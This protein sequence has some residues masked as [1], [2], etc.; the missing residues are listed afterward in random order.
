M[1]GPFTTASHT[2]TPG[3]NPGSALWNGQLKALIDAFGPGTAYTPTWT[4][5]TTNPTLNNGTLLGRYWQIQKMVL[6]QVYL[7]IGGST[8]IGSGAY[9]L[10]LPVQAASSGLPWLLTGQFID[11]STGNVYRG[12]GRIDSGGTTI[13]R[14]TFVDAA[15]GP[16]G[17]SSAAPVV[18]ATSDTVLFDGWYEA[19]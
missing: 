14:G 16:N 18:P 19:A 5:S 7:T 15:T 2:F 11:S 13:A 9:S 8:A 10:S 3:E 1:S 4:A 6:V 12:E 17:W